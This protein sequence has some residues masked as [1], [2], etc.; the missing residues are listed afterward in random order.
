VKPL[1]NLWQEIQALYPAVIEEKKKTIKNKKLLYLKIG[2]T[3]IVRNIQEQNN[4][5]WKLFVK[6]AEG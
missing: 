3:T 6:T 5:K 2:N 1:A 4:Y